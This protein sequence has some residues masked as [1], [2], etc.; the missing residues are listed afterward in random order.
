[1]NYPS[2]ELMNALMAERL[3]EAE[4]LRR[5]RNAGDRAVPRPRHRW[6]RWLRELRGRPG[7]GRLGRRAASAAPAQPSGRAPGE[8]WP[9]PAPRRLAG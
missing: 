3:A 7:V 6:R 8:G 2:P 4:R 9:D 1:M 5:H